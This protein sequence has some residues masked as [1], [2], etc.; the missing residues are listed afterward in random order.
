MIIFLHNIDKGGQCSITV[1]GMCSCRLF[2]A[3][4][5][6]CRVMVRAEVRYHG[7]LSRWPAKTMTARASAGSPHDFVKV[8]EVVPVP[9][10]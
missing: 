3:G 1:A 9:K 8:A 5:C 7:K 4:M 6:F 2:R 10:V